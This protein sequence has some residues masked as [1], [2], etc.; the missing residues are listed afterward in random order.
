MACVESAGKKV[1]RPW[2]GRK[3]SSSA[4]IGQQYYTSFYHMKTGAI[5]WFT[6]SHGAHGR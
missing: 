3:G 4:V 1:I 2:K 6:F 5:Q